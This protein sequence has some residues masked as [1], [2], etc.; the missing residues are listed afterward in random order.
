MTN[1]SYQK[2]QISSLTFSE[3]EFF[4]TLY[5]LCSITDTAKKYELT[6]PAASRVLKKLRGVFDDPLFIR[7]NPKFLP[8]NR[9]HELAI[10]IEDVL[11]RMN[12]MTEHEEFDPATLTRRFR[13]VAADNAIMIVLRDF[14]DKFYE[15]APNAVLEFQ[16]VGQGM[17]QKLEDGLVDV[18]FYP[19][20]R[21]IPP[22]VHERRLYPV[23]YKLCVRKGHPLEQYWLE[24]QELPLEE[25]AKYRK[26][27]IA[28]QLENEAQVYALD[29]MKM[30]GQECQK[31]GLSLP[32][33]VPIPTILEKTDLTVLLPDETAQV[34]SQTYAAKIALLPYGDSSENFTYWTRLIW[35]ERTHY[36]TVMQWFRGL[37]VLHASK[38]HGQQH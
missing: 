7:S 31:I 37:L 12:A 26:I 24:H 30:L 28:N 5:R 8:T 3:L 18:A 4:L 20:T 9:A 33:F 13:I 14:I 32:Y 1:H 22:K 6:V 17:F 34:L 16:Q 21:N 35:H 29:E 15:V 23:H 36:D 11:C 38:H 27:V 25:I 19:S 2:S 10:Q